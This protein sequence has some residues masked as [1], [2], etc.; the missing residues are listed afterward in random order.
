MRH[1]LISKSLAIDLIMS[2]ENLKHCRKTIVLQCYLTIPWCVIFIYDNQIY[3]NEN[4]D[5]F[6]DLND[7]P[8][9]DDWFSYEYIDAKFKNE[10]DKTK[11]QL[12]GNE[13][14]K[15]TKHYVEYINNNTNWLK[16][17]SIKIDKFRIDCEY[18]VFFMQM[19]MQCNKENGSTSLFRNLIIPRLPCFEKLDLSQFKLYI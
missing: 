6:K 3:L 18:I 7:F 8:P 17:I 4:K 19:Y 13:M 11:G 5:V 12:A 10:I 1:L 9:L 14:L 2:Q 16:A 15:E